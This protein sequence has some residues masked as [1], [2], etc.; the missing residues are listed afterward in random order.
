M[1]VL[2]W[3]QVALLM[4]EYVYFSMH[5][6]VLNC[7]CGIF[8]KDL[9]FLKIK[10]R[11]P[12]GPFRKSCFMIVQLYLWYEKGRPGGPFRKACFIIADLGLVYFWELLKRRPGRRIY[13]WKYSRQQVFAV[14]LSIKSACRGFYQLSKSR[15]AES[16]LASKKAV[17][18][19][20]DLSLYLLDFIL[21]N[22]L[23]LDSRSF[24]LDS[25]STFIRRSRAWYQ[26]K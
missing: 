24:L 23:L 6:N 21:Q 11:R 22:L 5:C 3:I 18:R 10:K 19:P 2:L 13:V 26:N 8:G 1:L 25:K 20:E 17:F 14:W 7:L 9:A 4:C 16:Q 12:G 15:V